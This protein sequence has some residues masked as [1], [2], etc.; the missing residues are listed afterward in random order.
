MTLLKYRGH[1]GAIDR[2]GDENSFQFVTAEPANQRNIE[3]SLKP[4]VEL[5]NAI[6]KVTALFSLALNLAKYDQI[7]DI[8]SVV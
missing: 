8:F 1:T 5:V 4:R 2:C 3:L 7:M 6:A